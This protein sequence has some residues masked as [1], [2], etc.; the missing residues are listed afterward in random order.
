MTLVRN[1]WKEK[2]LPKFTKNEWRTKCQERVLQNIPCI[3]RYAHT[4][5]HTYTYAQKHV[6]QWGTELARRAEGKERSGR[7]PLGF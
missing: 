6:H 7:R 4:H 1:E 2:R 5:I 3:H